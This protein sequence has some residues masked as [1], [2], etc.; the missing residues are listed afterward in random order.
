MFLGEE[1]APKLAEHLLPVLLPA[2]GIHVPLTG[3]R[4]LLQRGQLLL[5]AAALILLLMTMNLRGA[6]ESGTVFAIPTYG[7]MIAGGTLRHVPALHEGRFD[8]EAYLRALD[9]AVLMG[10]GRESWSCSA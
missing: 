9:R 6:R 10:S 7:F 5:V 4:L 1:V 8:P 3:R 2:L